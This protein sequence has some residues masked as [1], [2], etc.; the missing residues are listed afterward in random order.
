MAYSLYAVVNIT[1]G[2]SSSDL[3][4]SIPLKSGILIST[5]INNEAVEYCKKLKS[6]KKW[7]GFSIPVAI[8]SSTKELISFEKNP[9]WGGIYYPYF[10]KLITELT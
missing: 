8:N 1:S 4:K 3:I 2:R 6:G 5:N 9:L 7:A 10:R